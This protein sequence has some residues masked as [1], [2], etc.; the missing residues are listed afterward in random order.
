[1]SVNIFHEFCF[2]GNYLHKFHHLDYLLV[3]KLLLIFMDMYI[4]SHNFM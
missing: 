1:M 4:F 3:N 2:K